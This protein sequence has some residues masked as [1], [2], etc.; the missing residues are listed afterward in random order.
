MTTTHKQQ[1]LIDW[2][3]PQQQKLIKC[4][5]K[6]EIVC[7]VEAN[8]AQQQQQKSHFLFGFYGMRHIPHQQHT[9]N[10]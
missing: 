9:K 7:D 6:R 3:I 8:S 4:V 2:A 10:V 5:I 1:Q